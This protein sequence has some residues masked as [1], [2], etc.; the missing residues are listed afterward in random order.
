MYYVPSISSISLYDAVAVFFDN[1]HDAVISHIGYP[2]II[3]T[4]V[5][6]IMKTPVIIITKRRPW[7]IINGIKAPMPRRNIN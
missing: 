1:R 6:M 4:S 2:S 7:N 3:R 5:V